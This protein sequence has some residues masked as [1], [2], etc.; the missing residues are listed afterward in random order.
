VHLKV[1]TTKRQFIFES[2]AAIDGGIRDTHEIREGLP[3]VLPVP[4]AQ[5]KAGPLRDHQANEKK[6]FRRIAQ[7]NTVQEIT[8]KGGYF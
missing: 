8:A 3:G 1:S 5:S 6:I 4:L 2:A 7:G